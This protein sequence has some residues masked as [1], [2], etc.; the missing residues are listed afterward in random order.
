ML[1]FITKMNKEENIRKIVPKELLR[2]LKRRERSELIKKGQQ[3]ED[4]SSSMRT[5]TVGETSE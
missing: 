5:A 4:L 3:V 2:E 1:N